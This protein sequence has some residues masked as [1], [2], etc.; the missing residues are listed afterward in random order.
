MGRLTSTSIELSARE[1][2]SYSCGRL[3]STALTS[4]VPSPTSHP[5]HAR[6]VKILMPPRGSSTRG[7]HRAS[8]DNDWSRPALGLEALPASA[9]H[10]PREAVRNENA[11]RSSGAHAAGRVPQTESAVSDIPPPPLSFSALREHSDSETGRARPPASLL[12]RRG[13]VGTPGR[14]L[15]PDQGASR[16]LNQD[17]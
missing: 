5:K 15:R 2:A 8:P 11:S 12:P 7:V 6:M 9:E 4:P 3:K 14:I 1:S 13:S 10:C 17:A 16:T